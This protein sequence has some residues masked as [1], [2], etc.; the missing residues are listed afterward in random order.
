MPIQIPP[1]PNFSAKLG[2][3]GQMIARLAIAVNKE[4]D[5]ANTSRFAINSPY[6]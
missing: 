1:T 3:K 2:K 4:K 6:I 5:K